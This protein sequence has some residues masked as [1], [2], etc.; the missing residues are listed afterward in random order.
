M[1]L[2]LSRPRAV[3]AMIHGSLLARR[4]T[5]AAAERYLV[6]CPAR[7]AGSTPSPPWAIASLTSFCIWV[8]IS[9][10]WVAQHHSP[11]RPPQGVSAAK[12][13][14]GGGVGVIRGPGVMHCDPGERWQYSHCLHCLGPSPGMHRE[15][16]VFAGAGAVHPVQP[17]LDPESGLV[18]SGDGAVG[19]LLPGP[20]QEATQAGG[21]TGGDPGDRPR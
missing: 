6:T 14:I 19:D 10:A 13:V 11:T 18:E 15:Q 1:P 20:L 4:G 7:A 17:A 16:G 21:G 8:S 12:L 3:T 9:A 2:W 5:V